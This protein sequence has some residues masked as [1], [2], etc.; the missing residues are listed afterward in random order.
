MSV[1]RGEGPSRR[2]GEIGSRPRAAL[3][4][5]GTAAGARACPGALPR[6]EVDGQSTGNPASRQA[7]VPPS[8]FMTR[9]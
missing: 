2:L 3:R 7:V 9:S 4:S 1:E 8:M 5:A 6:S